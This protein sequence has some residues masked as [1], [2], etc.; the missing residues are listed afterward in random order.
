MVPTRGQEDVAKQ[1]AQL[2][3]RTK[4]M[5]IQ[6]LRQA[7][8]GRSR[9]SLFRDLV[10]LGYF[11]SYSHAGR[12]Y[13]LANIPEFDEYG[14]WRYEAIG[15]SQRGTL[16]ATVAWRVDE[17]EAGCTHAELEALLRLEVHNTLLGLVRAGAICREQVAGIY[18]YVSIDKECA[19]RQLDVRRKQIVAAERVPKLPPDEIV[20]LVL[21]EVLHASEG[22]PASP[23]VAARL[24]AR[25]EEI[26]PEQVERVYNHFRLEPGKKTA[27]PR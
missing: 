15:F 27:E 2:F 16:R 22:L 13:T 1:T 6:A 18:L 24:A 26:A 10:R 21:V 9:R 11:S 3:R 12:Y 14:L 7:S 17:A 20:L 8:Q 4:V 5:D 23:I 25:G 19:V